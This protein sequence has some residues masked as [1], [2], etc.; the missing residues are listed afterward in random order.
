VRT[1]EVIQSLSELA[2]EAEKENARIFRYGLEKVLTQESGKAVPGLNTDGTIIIVKD[3]RGIAELLANK[4]QKINLSVKLVENLTAASAKVIYLKGLNTLSEPDPVSD[5]I[6]LNYD[7]FKT[8]RVCSQHLFNNS[9]LFIT[10]FDTGADS[11]SPRS[12]LSG[13]AALAKTAAL[14]W[15]KAFVKAIDIKSANMNKEELA[16][17]IFQELAKGGLETEVLLSTEGRFTY[18]H[19]ISDIKVRSNPLRESDVIVVS[20]GA[21]GVTASCLME[22]AGRVPLKIALLGRTTIETEPE[23]L[24]GYKSDAELKKAILDFN[25]EK[26]NKIS[27]LELSGQVRNIIAQREIAAN[28]M[29]IRA[30]GSEVDYYSVDISDLAQVEHVIKQ[31]KA[32]WGIVKGFIHGAGIV[33]DKYIHDKT[34][35]Q[36]DK[37]FTTK[38]QGLRNLLSVLKDEMLTHICCFSSVAGRMGN[39]G[40]VDYAMANEILNKVSQSEQ[41]RRKGDCS[42]KSI[43]WGPWEGGMVSPELRKMFEAQGVTL[44]PIDKGAKIFADEM[45]DSSFKNV[46]S[47]VSGRFSEINQD[48]KEQAFDLLVLN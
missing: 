39:S 44:I 6:Q 24:T 46:E 18:V 11:A 7:A 32:K 31:V 21:R 16:D 33:S 10:I 3:N 19:S 42:V 1:D 14:E 8:A 23:Y 4:L 30:K 17:A 36:F 48:S 22:L 28:I 35:T 45:E 12:W 34:D 13:L 38:V 40:Q 5:A 41:L 15:Q 2:K 43:N 47:I 20:G 27:P 26:G 9:G 25:Q 29:A 37:V